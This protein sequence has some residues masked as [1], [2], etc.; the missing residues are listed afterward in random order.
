MQSLRRKTGS[1]RDYATAERLLARSVAVS[2]PRFAGLALPGFGSSRRKPRLPGGA[3]LHP[4]SRIWRVVVIGSVIGASAYGLWLSG[5]DG[6]IYGKVTNDLSSLAVAVGFG[7]KQITIE[8]QQRLSDGEL[9][10]ALSAGPGTNI[11]SFNTDEAKQR[12]EAVPWI[13]HAQVMRLLPSTL[14]VV[15][16]ERTPFAVWQSQGQTYVVD[17]AGA[18]LAPAVREAYADLPLVVGEGANKNAADLFIT[19]APYENLRS[20][21]VAAFRVGDRRWTLKLNPGVDV[22]LPDDNVETAL[23]TLLDL[24]RERN[25]LAKIRASGRPATTPQAT[26]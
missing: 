10:A 3:A 26:G 24:D 23:D 2:E 19:L 22:L 13:K 20:R 25:L 11:L 1:G 12:L 8:G 9:A 21:L 15:V 5:R 16:E 7:V 4:R 17:S 6:P 18:V 14:Q